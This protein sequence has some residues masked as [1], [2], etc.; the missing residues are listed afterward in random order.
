MDQFHVMHIALGSYI[1]S[2]KH[3]RNIYRSLLFCRYT[4]MSVSNCKRLL[5]SQ[6]E[7]KWQLEEKYLDSALK[8]ATYALVAI[9]RLQL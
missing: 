5:T 6:L 1:P 2:W 9:L 4:Y 7:G 3:N 8:F